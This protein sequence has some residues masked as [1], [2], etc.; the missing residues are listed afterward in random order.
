VNNDH[1]PLDPP[2]VAKIMI[3]VA[4]PTT[5]SST[6]TSTTST[7]T[8]T[9]TTTTTTTATGQ[10]VTINLTA[11]NIAFNMTTITVPAGA[12][13]TINFQ[14]NDSVP[15]NFSLFTNSSA[16]PPALFQGQVISGGGSTT[17]KFTAPS[18]PGTYFF[19]CDVHPT[20]MTGSFI[21][22]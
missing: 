17:Y 19:R 2:V 16:T 20:I 22:Q 3:N 14:N 18:Q 1:T 8:S 10:P 7:T 5:T 15:H 12:S 11:Q 13:V 6:S 4:A 21:V 9:T